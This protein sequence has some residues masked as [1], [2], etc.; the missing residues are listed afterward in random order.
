MPPSSLMYGFCI[1]ENSLKYKEQDNNRV[2]P[3]R[4]TLQHIFDSYH[5]YMMFQIFLASTLNN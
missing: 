3:F 2:K 1:D 5:V 4:A